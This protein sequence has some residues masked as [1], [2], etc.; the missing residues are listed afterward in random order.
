[1]KQTIVVIQLSL[2]ILSP[3]CFQNVEAAVPIIGIIGD[4]KEIK[5]SQ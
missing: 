2:C 5:T 4:A 1:M 3:E